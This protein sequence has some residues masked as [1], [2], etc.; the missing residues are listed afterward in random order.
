[1]SLFGLDLLKVR[2]SAPLRDRATS[3]S[4]RK[5]MAKRVTYPQLLPVSCS[6][7]CGTQREYS[8]IYVLTVQPVDSIDIHYKAILNL[9]ILRYTVRRTTADMPGV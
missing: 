7:S 4:A 2:Y 1:M 8:T 9:A 5:I 3:R 6:A